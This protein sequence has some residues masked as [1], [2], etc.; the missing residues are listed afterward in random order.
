LQHLRKIEKTVVA[1]DLVPTEL[2]A[3][4]NT[5]LMICAVPLVITALLLYLAVNA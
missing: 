3:R 2:A 1:D 4:N 5:V